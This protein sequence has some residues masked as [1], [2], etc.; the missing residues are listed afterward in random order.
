M[1]LQPVDADDVEA[2]R[3]FL[4]EADLTLAGLDAPTVR[5]WVDRDDDGSVVGSTGYET[6]ADGVHVLVRS[7]AVAPQHRG[8]GG[9]TRLAR[10]AIERATE[11]GA[12]RAWLFSRRS[13]PFWQSLGFTPADR[14]ALAAALPDT[15]QVRLFRRTGQLEHEVAWSR[16]LT[17]G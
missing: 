3:A 13:G 4:V 12:E 8:A 10:F 16:E 11:A 9:G 14:D 7:V 17:S 6:S 15:H 1:T 5:L 2:L